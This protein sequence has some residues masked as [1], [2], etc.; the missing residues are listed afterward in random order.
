MVAYKCMYC[1][2]DILSNCVFE[3]KFA[4][5]EYFM[6]A[7]IKELSDKCKCRE[8]VKEDAHE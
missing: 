5:F 7:K 8:T 4:E 6:K 2:R 1:G 3:G